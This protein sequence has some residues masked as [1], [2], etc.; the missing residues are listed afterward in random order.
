M[1]TLTFQPNLDQGLHMIHVYKVLFG[2]ATSTTIS[3]AAAVA[4]TV[5]A[6]PDLL[7]LLQWLVCLLLSS[8]PPHSNFSH[9]DYCSW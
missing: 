5:I 6:D 2:I 7:L 3:I 4:A 9:H 8:L 1:V